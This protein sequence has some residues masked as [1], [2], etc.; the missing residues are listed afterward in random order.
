M[1]DGTIADQVFT[2]AAQ[3]TIRTTNLGGYAAVHIGITEYTVTIFRNNRAEITSK[4]EWNLTHL[5]GVYAT[6]EQDAALRAAWARH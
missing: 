6:P 1:I 4:R 5:N 2:K 3:G